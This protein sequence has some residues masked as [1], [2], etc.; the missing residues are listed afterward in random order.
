[1]ASSPTAVQSS[2]PAPYPPSRAS[3]N[4]ADISDQDEDA[5]W[6]IAMGLAP[7]PSSIADSLPPEEDEEDTLVPSPQKENQKQKKSIT[8]E[9]LLNSPSG[10]ETPITSAILSQSSDITKSPVSSRARKDRQR[11]NKTSGSREGKSSSSRIRFGEVEADMD[12]LRR[13]QKQLDYGKNTVG[14]Q[15]YTERVPR[16]QRTKEDPNTPDKFRVYSRRSWDQ[17]I[18]I[19]RQKLHAYDPNDG[20]NDPEMEISEIMS[21]LSFSSSSSYI[22]SSPFTSEDDFPPISGSES[23]SEVDPRDDIAYLVDFEENS[24]FMA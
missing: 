23:N 10:V 20:A 13:R 22:P 6:D 12:V 19:W 15:N 7:E 4:W 14:Y 17:L 21:D 1:M 5:V 2:S 8:V 18:K 9:E 3:I 16:P 11:S 24:H